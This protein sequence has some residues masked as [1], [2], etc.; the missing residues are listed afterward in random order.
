[1]FTFQ[2]FCETSLYMKEIAIR[3][4]NRNIGYLCHIRVNFN[5]KYL[6]L[7]IDKNK[8]NRYTSINGSFSPALYVLKDSH[9]C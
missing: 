6:I 9:Y 7:T 4:I 5:Y 1:M 2:V 8:I 3:W